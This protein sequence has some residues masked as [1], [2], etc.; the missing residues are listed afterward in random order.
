MKSAYQELIPSLSSGA[1]APSESTRWQWGD[2]DVHVLNVGSQDSP[3]QMVLLHGAGG[4]AAAMQPIAERLA[5]LG[6][7]ISIPDLPGYGLTKV[8]DPAAVRYDHWHELA[9]EL[10]RTLKDERPM[11]VL[12]ASMGGLLAY[13]AAAESKAADALV[14]TCLLD[15]REEAVR[16]RLSWSPTLGRNALPLMRW[17]AGPLARLRIP[18]RLLADMSSISNSPELTKVVIRDPRG[19]GSWMPLVWMRSFL[20]WKVRIEPEHYPSIPVLMVHPGEDR[21]IPLEVSKPFFNRIAAPKELV[22]LENAG[23]F[24]IEQPGLDQMVAA[25]ERLLAQITVR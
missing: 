14:V 7:Y 18:V 1:G 6:A 4:N 13:D 12:G 25:V 2:F 15:P 19:G 3:V 23:H 24:P 20:E 10:V 17:L 9:T 5:R 8:P 11:V 16:E 22:V 21:W